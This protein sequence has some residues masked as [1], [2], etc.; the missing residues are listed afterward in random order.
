[1]KGY[2]DAA[3]DG[4]DV[5][6]YTDLYRR[7][8]DAVKAVRPG[9]LVGGPY[10]PLDLWAD[11][12][13]AP[14]DLR[15]PWGITDRRGLDAV[16]YWLANHGG[17]D[18]VCVDGGSAT[19]DAGLST[20]AVTAT[21]R[22]TATTAWVRARTDLPVWWSEFYPEPTPGADGADDAASPA[23]AAATLAAVAAL[24]RGGAAVALLWQP[25][26]ASSLPY[27][28]LWTDTGDPGGGQ[29][30]ALADPWAWLA[31][32][33][34]SGTVDLGRSPDGRVLGFRAGDGTLVANTG[35]AEV[36]IAGVAVGAYG[37]AVL[38]R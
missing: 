3:R 4:W 2:F 14:S 21:D 11:D 1:M 6:T 25:Q 23:R 32:R 33:L 37:S 38:P 17:A 8:R 26:A 30:T 9:V 28:A 5:A 36:S 31:G 27:A 15:G 7:V 34:A 13:V 35:A 16:E 29:A 24:A 12:G 19:R 22:F 10:V 18:F 20:D